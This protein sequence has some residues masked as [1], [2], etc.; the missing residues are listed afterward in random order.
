MVETILTFQS[1]VSCNYECYVSIIS[2]F[3]RI[4]TRVMLLLQITISTRNIAE[5]VINRETCL[6][7]IKFY[8]GIFMKFN[9]HPIKQL[10]FAT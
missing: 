3:N 7:D 5:L 2:L 1:D 4:A 10:R 8:Q 6:G 9:Q